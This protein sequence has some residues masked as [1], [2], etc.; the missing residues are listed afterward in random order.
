LAGLQTSGLLIRPAKTSYTAG[1]LAEMGRN[2]KL[3]AF[4]AR[5][6]FDRNKIVKVL[7]L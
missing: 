2:K 4:F 5:K 6:I 3:W 1:T 7:V